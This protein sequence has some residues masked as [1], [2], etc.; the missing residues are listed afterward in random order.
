MIS[1]EIIGDE[2]LE[3]FIFLNTDYADDAGFHG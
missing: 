3:K 2:K 1:D